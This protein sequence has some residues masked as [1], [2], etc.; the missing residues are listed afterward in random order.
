MIQGG[1]RSRFALKAL[2]SAGIFFQ[3]S[4]EELQRDVAPQAEVF[5]FIHHAHS[6]AA[7]LAQNAVVGDRFT[8]HEIRHSGVYSDGRPLL[9]ASQ[10]KRGP[11]RVAGKCYSLASAPRS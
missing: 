11:L 10:R 6:A 5:G 8:N 9:E 7:K 3:L 4:G 1:S 2:Q